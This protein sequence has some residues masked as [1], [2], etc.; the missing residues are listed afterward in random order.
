[1]DLSLLCFDIQEMI[2]QQVDV[3]RETNNNKIKFNNVINKIN[4]IYIELEDYNM[5]VELYTLDDP[6]IYS[7]FY[8]EGDSFG[9][10]F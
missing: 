10:S 9:N 6:I 2:G 4:E 1:M 7:E 8:F 5:G 3:I